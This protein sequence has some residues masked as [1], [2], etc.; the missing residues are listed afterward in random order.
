MKK[1]FAILVMA[2]FSL[3]VPGFAATT[4]GAG[5]PSALASH[6]AKK[7]HKKS[8]RKKSGKTKPTRKKGS[9]KPGS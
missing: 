2:G 5:T 4:S 9:K 6:S 1:L 3:A 8:G 7:T